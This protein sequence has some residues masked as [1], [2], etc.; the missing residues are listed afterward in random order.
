MSHSRK[1]PRRDLRGKRA[2]EAGWWEPAGTLRHRLGLGRRRART[3]GVPISIGGRGI[4]RQRGG[5][6]EELLFRASRCEAAVLLVMERTDQP[7]A[8]PSPF[9]SLLALLRREPGMEWLP[10][11]PDGCSGSGGTGGLEAG[12]EEG[13]G[14]CALGGAGRGGGRLT[15][16]GG[17]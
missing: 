2:E 4:K 1:L 7:A 10:C 9:W 11:G 15:G 13:A 17:G 3:E 12:S 8:A 14:N 6:I 16:G 5:P